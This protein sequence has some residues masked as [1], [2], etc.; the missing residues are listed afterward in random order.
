MPLT[1]TKS[2]V[3]DKLSSA[4]PSAIDLVV[5]TASTSSPGMSTIKCHHTPYGRPRPQ[6]LLSLQMN[7]GPSFVQV[8]YPERPR[9]LQASAA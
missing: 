7:A 6:G 4:Q 1:A 9:S 5:N 3:A 8:T 2:S